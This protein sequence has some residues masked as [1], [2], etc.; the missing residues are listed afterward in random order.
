MIGQEVSIV[1]KWE[2]KTIY[3]DSAISSLKDS[4]DFDQMLNEYG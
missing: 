2:Y 4:D 1:K 3:W